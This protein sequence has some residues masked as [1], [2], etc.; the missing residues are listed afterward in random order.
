MHDALLIKDGKIERI[1]IGDF[2]DIQKAVGNTFTSAF[3]LPGAG[4]PLTIQ[5]YCDDEFLLTGL[6][7]HFSVGNDIYRGGYAYGGPV[8]IMGVDERDGESRS[9]TEAEMRAF[10]ISEHHE[11]S[12]VQGM[13][14]YLPVLTYKYPPDE[15][16]GSLFG[17]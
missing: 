3:R 16:K 13:M 6:P 14:M 4:Y 11:M 9:L 15:A 1:Q 2:R 10:S 5:A 12:S 17:D 8:V 7:M